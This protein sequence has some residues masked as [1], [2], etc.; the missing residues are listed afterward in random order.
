MNAESARQAKE[1]NRWGR[2]VV[3]VLVLTLC[4]GCGGRKVLTG[5]D[6]SPA[7]KEAVAITDLITKAASLVAQGKEQQVFALM[8]GELPKAEQAAVM[9]ALKKLSRTPGWKVERVSRFTPAY[10]RA[11]VS[12]EGGPEK[13]VTINLLRQDSSFVFTGGG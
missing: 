5:K 10:F 6:I 4:L 13:S 11:M 3:A 8:K 9:A 1:R 12:L 7:A 2:G